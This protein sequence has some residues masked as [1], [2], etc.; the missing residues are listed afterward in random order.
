MYRDE[1]V[2][3]VFIELY[4]RKKIFMYDVIFW[5]DYMKVKFIEFF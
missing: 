5:N 4:S 2:F 3:D 1:E